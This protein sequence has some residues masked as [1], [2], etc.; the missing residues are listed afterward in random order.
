MTAIDT[1]HG[2]VAFEGLIRAH[3]SRLSSLRHG[4]ACTK[5]T[6][7]EK[8]QQNPKIVAR[9]IDDDPVGGHQGEHSKSWGRLRGR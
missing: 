4:K 8:L 6:C 3:L 9:T 7:G 1:T 5:P 2:I